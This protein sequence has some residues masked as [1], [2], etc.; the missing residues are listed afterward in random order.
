MNLREYEG[1]KLFKQYG[2]PVPN[3]YLIE[4]NISRV[5][6]VGDYVLKAQVY[7]GDR[8]K[9]GGILFA[10]GDKLYP[11]IDELFKKTISGEKVRQILVEEKINV[12]S[13][14]YVSL[15]YDTDSRGPVLALS[16]SGGTGISKAH[17]FP[18]DVTLSELPAFWVREKL[19]EADFSAK[20]FGLV[21]VIQ[22]LYELFIKE[23]AL[24]AE[25]NPVF[26]IADPKVGDPPRAGGN[27]FIAGDAKVILDDEKINPSERRFVNMGGDIAILASGGG[28]S[29]LNIDALLKYGGKPA[30]YTEYSGNPKSEI[31]RELTKKVLNQ[32]GIKGLWVVGVKANFTDIYETMRGFIEGLEAV[33]PK[34]KYPIVIRRDGPRQ[35]EA[36]E[37]LKEFGRSRGYNLHIYGSEMAMEQSAKV[38][39]ELAYGKKI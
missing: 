23:Y 38:M 13:E 8:M 1:K 18:V 5:P 36:A 33:H 7:S 27:K 20:D 10:G 21:K 24:L 12:A 31:V 34:P 9:A 15:S 35:K 16:N 11:T 19:L 4:D 22:D 37:M 3:S 6:Q 17:K 30:N 29:M 2:I 14:Y 28:A 25:I 39:V 32:P 26:K